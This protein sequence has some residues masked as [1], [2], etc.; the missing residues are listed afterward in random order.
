[1]TKKSTQC[2]PTHIQ[3]IIAHCKAIASIT[4]QQS[5]QFQ[6]LALKQLFKNSTP[7][8]IVR[9]PNKKPELITPS[10]YHISVSHTKN[11]ICLCLHTQPIGCDLE[12]LNRIIPDRV[13]NRNQPTP[14][15]RTNK[16]KVIL[17]TQWEAQCK[18]VYSGLRF[19][20]SLHPITACQTIQWYDVSL[21]IASQTT[22]IKWTLSEMTLPDDPSCWN[23]HDISITP[24]TNT[25]RLTIPTTKK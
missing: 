21:S 10:G 12:F 7:I 19:P 1:M 25:P 20:I 17:W 8:N 9:R 5:H 2:N 22:P 16:E 11:I 14:I 6:M 3:I 4:K 13:I 18:L 15:T 24:V 23:H